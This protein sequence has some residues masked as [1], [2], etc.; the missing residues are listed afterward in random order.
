MS[1][2]CTVSLHDTLTA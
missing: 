2:S 1:A